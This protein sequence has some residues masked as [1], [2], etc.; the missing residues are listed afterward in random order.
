[1]A[2]FLF[3]IPQWFLSSG[4]V[5][6]GGLIYTYL[7]NSATPQAT[8]SES[9]GTSLN[10]NPVQLDSAGRAQIWLSAAAYKFVVQTSAGAAIMTIDGYNPDTLNTTV[11]ALTNTGDLT[12]QQATAATS[13]ANQSSNNLKIQATYWD[14]AAS[15]VDQ[16]NI[17]DVL[18]T[19]SNPTSTLTVLHSGTSGTTSINLNAPVSTGRATVTSLTAAVA[20]TVVGTNSIS[21][22][23]TIVAPTFISNSANVALTGVVEL[24]STDAIKW[25]NNA[26]GADIALQKTGATAGGIPADTLD[27][28]GFGAIEGVALI[29]TT[30]NPAQSGLVRG[31]NAQVLVAGRN[32]ANGADINAVTVNSGNLV[33]LGS[34]PFIIPAASDTAVGKATT[35]TLTNKT[36]T[37]AT[38][39]NSVTLLNEQGPA[40]EINGTGAAVT[41]YTYTLP[42]N[43]MQAGKGI[44][45]RY[46]AN[47]STGAGAMAHQ[48]TFGG[49]AY[50]SVTDSGATGMVFVEANIFNNA[51]VTNAQHGS[52]QSFYP[53][54]L[55]TGTAFTGLTSAIATTSNVTIAVTFNSAAGTKLTPGQ[56]IVELI[57]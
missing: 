23:G 12:M 47:H 37:G 24:A 17:Q 36:L 54:V 7:A 19:G 15:Q 18:G 51:G 27:A 8:W 50:F 16:W 49:T 2:K 35:D 4:A 9:T 14:G 57:Q 10:S 33:Q 42:A 1:M 11:T 44:R 32:A 53:G 30:A 43:V 38:S 22:N 29:G 56:F 52:T 13:G 45:I 31:A 48:L 20:L 46:W 40:A 34:G 41:V 6:A 21:A 5:N 39:G 3:P 55:I 25:R 26:N 28:S